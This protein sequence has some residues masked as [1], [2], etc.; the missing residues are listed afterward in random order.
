MSP[1]LLVAVPSL[2]EFF[3]HAVDVALGHQAVSADEATACYLVDLLCEYARTR[4]DPFAEPLAYVVAEAAQSP[5]E[6]S[7]EQLRQVGD[8]SL[9]V[10]GYCGDSLPRLQLDPDY[11]VEVGGTA[12]RK[13][14][15]LL[16][17]PSGSN[18]LVLVFSELGTEFHRFVQV[19]SDVK[20]LAN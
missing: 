13:L 20:Q 12:Y 6:Q 5:P 10:A 7:V 8:H 16:R 17:I 1:S 19:L 4:Q 14:S 11:F 9:Y 3:R 18:Q 2:R 15:K